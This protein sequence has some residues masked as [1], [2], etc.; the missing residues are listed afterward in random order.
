MKGQKLDDCCLDRW[1][2]WY[3]HIC[4]YFVQYEHMQGLLL[5][6][7]IDIRTAASVQSLS[8]FL[9]I[10]I[11]FYGRTHVRSLIVTHLHTHSCSLYFWQ[12]YHLF[13]NSVQRQA[14][15]IGI[16]LQI[17]LKFFRI[18]YH[19]SFHFFK[20]ASILGEKSFLQEKLTIGCCLK[21]L[22]IWYG[23]IQQSSLLHGWVGLSLKL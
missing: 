18:F 7:L 4:D 17:L 21:P 20:V 6:I 12:G 15:Q 9:C 3:C 23:E 16:F 8:C 1:L 11:E 13:L 19:L 14:N 22:V 2:K 10:E 5:V